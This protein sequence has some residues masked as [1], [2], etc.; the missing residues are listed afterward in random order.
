MPIFLRGEMVCMRV[1]PRPSVNMP[2]GPLARES[3]VHLRKGSGVAIRITS[4]ILMH[5]T[6]SRVDE[7]GR[8]TVS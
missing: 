1:P 5:S 6:Y 7:K 4:C 2:P 3:L 8:Q